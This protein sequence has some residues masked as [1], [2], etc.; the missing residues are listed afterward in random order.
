MVKA[1]HDSDT[2]DLLSWEPPTVA[3][4]YNEKEV[5]AATLQAQICR[6]VTVALNDCG[7]PR[8]LI[9]AEMSEYLGEEVSVNML[10]AYSSPARDKHNISAVR[11]IALAI[12]T[13]DIRLF[14]IGPDRLGHAVV[15]DRYL[16]L[17]MA[18]QMQDKAQELKDK[19]EELNKAAA[20]EEKKARG[21]R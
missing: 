16:S 10:N 1:R 6:A 8:D 2:L 3:V 4:G 11:L 17:I 19:A 20:L 7:K 14:S 5:R 9:A 12:V 13:A 21:V 15:E 18:K